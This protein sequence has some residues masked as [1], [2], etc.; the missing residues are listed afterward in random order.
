MRLC[1]FVFMGVLHC[2]ALC[3]Y[4]FPVKL[5]WQKL[6]T[7]LLQGHNVLIISE[8]PSVLGGVRRRVPICRFCLA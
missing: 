5:L 2:A 1:Q 6:T 8:Q 3:L 7:L 4:G